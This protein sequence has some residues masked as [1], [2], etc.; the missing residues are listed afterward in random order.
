MLDVR[1]T[2]EAFLSSLR[3]STRSD[4]PYPHWLMEHCLPQEA[5]T[6]VTG[7]PIAPAH[8]EDTQGR[9]ETHNDSRIHFGE[10]YRSR[11]GVMDV[12]ARVFQSQNV[13]DA[14]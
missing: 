8:I 9:R 13:V 6:A 7:L 2:T 11:Y 5:V 10:Q 3:Y 14:L 1:T 4:S 12:L